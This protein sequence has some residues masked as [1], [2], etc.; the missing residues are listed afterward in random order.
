MSK[1]TSKCFHLDVQ[2]CYSPKASYSPI[3]TDKNLPLG[4]N[5]ADKNKSKRSLPM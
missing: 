3:K 1:N 5:N 2:G 4:N